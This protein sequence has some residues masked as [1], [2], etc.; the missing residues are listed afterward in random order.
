MQLNS[1]ELNSSLLPEE[2]AQEILNRDLARESLTHFIE[3][4]DLA[5][6]PVTHHL[7]LI[8]HLEAL[9]RGDIDKLMVWMPPGSAKSTYTSVL[10]PPWYMGRN[11]EEPVLGVSNTTELAER[12][13][14][15]A[16]NLVSGGL[17]RNIFGFGCSEDTKA[18]GSWEN[19]RGGEFFAAGVVVLLPE[20]GPSLALLT[21]LLSLVKK[22]IL[23]G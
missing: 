7:L 4:L 16:R 19:E 10:F 8:E 23:N 18:A 13:S 14:R 3:Y 21:I 20:E 12:F 17:Y 15:R 6:K 9:E 22:P 1:V 2:A 11:P 5:Y